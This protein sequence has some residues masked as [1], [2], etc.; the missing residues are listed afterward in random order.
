MHFH[1]SSREPYFLYKFLNSRP[2]WQSCCLLPGFQHFFIFNGN[3]H[4]QTLLQ[5]G[6]TIQGRKNA[7]V[8]EHQTQG[9]EKTRTRHL[10]G[11]AQAF[12]ALQPWWKRDVTALQ[13]KWGHKLTPRPKHATCTPPFLENQ[14]KLQPT[15][16][17][18][19][20]EQ[21]H[22]ADTHL[23]GTTSLKE[24]CCLCV[25]SAEAHLQLP[26]RFCL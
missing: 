2:P 26:Y 1:L 20:Q 13:L 18:C 25:S 24:G 15:I 3:L 19:L 21:V 22:W 16:P 14:I 6:T 9:G 7:S 23:L 8:L 4:L 5:K 10:S 17:P 12:L 11:E